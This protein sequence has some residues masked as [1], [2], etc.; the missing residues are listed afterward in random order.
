MKTLTIPANIL[1]AA[2]MT[3]A[4]KDIRYYL[5]G[6]M[7]DGKRISGTNG[8]ILFVAPFECDL[9]GIT[10]KTHILITP[11]ASI[12]GMK[13]DCVIDFSAMT[14]TDGKKIVTFAIVDGKFPD[15]DRV[16]PVE[17]EYKDIEAR[18]CPMVDGEYMASAA[19]IAGVLSAG[20]N[21]S[22]PAMV[23]YSR[24]DNSSL[25]FEYPCIEGAKTVLMP[26]RK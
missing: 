17:S 11:N 3:M 10:E 6:V 7:L 19:S 21:K 2:T 9:S 26:M 20:V 13:G 4:K 16:I 12:M 23:I 18:G 15:I 24:D 22:Y 8:H 5:N 1:K 25:V 14:I